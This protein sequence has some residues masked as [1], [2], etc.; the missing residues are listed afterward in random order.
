M[1]LTINHSV[2]LLILPFLL[3]EVEYFYQEWLDLLRI[4]LHE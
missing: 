1:D 3:I 2:Q 4:Y